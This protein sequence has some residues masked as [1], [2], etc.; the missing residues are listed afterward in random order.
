MRVSV[1]LAAIAAMIISAVL[2]VKLLGERPPAITPALYSAKKESPEASGAINPTGPQPKAV[3]VEADFTFGR[4]L[5]GEERSHDYAIRNDGAAVLTLEFGET[6]C[7]CTYSNMK[8]GDKIEVQPGETGHVTLSWKPTGQAEHFDKGA[9]LITNDPANPTIRLRILGMVTPRF[10]LNP[11]KEWVLAESLEGKPFTFVGRIASPIIEHFEITGCES[12]SPLV[13][14]DVVALS[15]AEVSKHRGAISGYEIRVSVKPDMPMGSFSYPLTIKTDVPEI[16]VDGSPGKPTEFEILLLGAH[17]GPIRPTGPEWID[18]KMAFSLGS[19]DAEVGKKI[20]M[21]VFIKNPPAEGFKL[22]E[23]PVCTPA[24]LKFELRPDEKSTGPSP[25]YRL[26]LEY[27]PGSHR[28]TY[29]DDSAAKVVLKT[30]HPYAETVE[31][32]VLFSAY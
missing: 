1:V 5:V 30:N 25:R 29:R 23:P 31:F 6:T 21:P 12:R 8:K 18:D 7:Q 2:V 26:T 28:G 13:S 17:R 16:T 27:P 9:S 19:F 24:A 32:L 10:I 11:E 3:A 4:M 15:S 22:T 20:S 14:T